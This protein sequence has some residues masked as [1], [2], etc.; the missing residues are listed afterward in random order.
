MKTLV[1]ALL[2]ITPNMLFAQTNVTKKPTAPRKVVY[3]TKKAFGVDYNSWFESLNFKSSDSTS[4]TK[5]QYYGFGLNYDLTFYEKDWGY[6]FLFGYAQGFA[7]AGQSGDSSSYYQKRAAW[8]AL[9]GGGRIF[10]RVNSRFD[11]GLN[12]LTQLRQTGWKSSGGFDPITPT[13][14]L[15]GFFAEARWRI[16]YR[17]EIVQS[18][19]QFTKDNSMAWRVGANYTLN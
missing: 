3:K 14:P 18:F 19:G 8:T 12:V 2:F 17:Y 7:V 5:S 1:I 6:G 10:T 9:L 13:N 16:N 4:S 11:L 15:T